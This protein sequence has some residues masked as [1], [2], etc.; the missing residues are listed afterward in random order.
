MA[1]NAFSGTVFRLMTYFTDVVSEQFIHRAT[2]NLQ[3]AVAITT[4]FN[5]ADSV[6]LMVKDHRA[7]AILI[8]FLKSKVTSN[9]RKTI[10]CEGTQEEEYEDVLPINSHIPPLCT[11][12]V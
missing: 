11:N 6:F 4:I 2:K 8:L 10:A 7:I 5:S 3:R 12:E 9:V 1:T